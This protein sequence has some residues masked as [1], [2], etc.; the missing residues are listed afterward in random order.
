[1]PFLIEASQEIFTFVTYCTLRDFTSSS[2][3]NQDLRPCKDHSVFRLCL[4]FFFLFFSVSS[5][6][7][8]VFV[9]WHSVLNDAT[10]SRISVEDLRHARNVQ[11]QFYHLFSGLFLFVMLTT[12]SVIFIFYSRDFTCISSSQ[13]WFSSNLAASS[14]NFTML[15]TFSLKFCHLF[16]GL[17]LAV[18]SSSF[19][20]RV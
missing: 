18:S 7:F 15:A 4:F 9:G 13:I 5:E 1:M 10:C 8:D 19:C 16:S 2:S 12:L 20:M 17:H 6:I 3:F 14:K 11:S